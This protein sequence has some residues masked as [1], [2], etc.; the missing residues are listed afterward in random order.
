MFGLLSNRISRRH[1]YA[2][3]L[4]LIGL[5]YVFYPIAGSVVEL[6]IYRVFYAVG[7]ASTTCLMTI[8]THDY[9]QEPSRGKLV[10]TCG[11]MGSF[12]AVLI[13]AVFGSL[14]ETFQAQVYCVMGHI[15]GSRP[16]I[17]NLG[18]AGK[19]NVFIHHRPNRR[20]VMGTG[21]GVPYGPV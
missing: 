3:G 16:R 9:V 5:A 1:V 10:A 14:L 11:V 12:G 18:C 19:G 2:G 13:S 4:A 21:Y 6:T 20:I 7:V 15:S 17:G 8:I